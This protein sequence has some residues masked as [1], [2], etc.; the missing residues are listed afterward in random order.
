MAR[1]VTIQLGQ[2]R[3]PAQVNSVISQDFGEQNRKS[4]VRKKGKKECQ[5]RRLVCLF[6]LESL[7]CAA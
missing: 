1:L 5:A 3:V 2:D 6:C 7:S 4:E